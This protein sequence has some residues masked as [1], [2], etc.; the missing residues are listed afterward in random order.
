MNIDIFFYRL[1]FDIENPRINNE[2][3]TVEGST[4]K[5]D[6]DRRYSLQTD[7]VNTG[8]V[9]LT[10]VQFGT[11]NIVLKDGFFEVD[12]ANISYLPI[13]ETKTV[14]FAWTANQ[15]GP[16]NIVFELEGGDDVM[17]SDESGDQVTRDVFVSGGPPPPP[18]NNDGISLLDFMPQ[19][20][21]LVIFGFIIFLFAYRMRQIHISPVDTGYD[22]DG[23]YKP[24]AVK[25][26]L[27]GEEKEKIGGTEKAALPAQEKAALPPAPDAAAAGRPGPA[28]PLTA[29]PPAPRPVA[30]TPVAGRPPMPGHPQP[31]RAQPLQMPR[32]AGGIPPR[33]G[34]PMPPRPGQPIPPRP[35]Q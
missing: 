25:E 3:I 23:T 21:L 28:S 12:R 33:P 2:T 30:P 13:G 27:K 32:P 19:L 10:P 29:Q 9:N 17:V 5:K 11:L 7:I 26:Q 16:H 4:E 18:P 22:E 35:G 6:L 24:W 14:F 15:P 34:Q 31:P 20:I 1:M 8:S